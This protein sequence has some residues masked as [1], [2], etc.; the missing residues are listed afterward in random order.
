[1]IC[2]QDSKHDQK[3]DISSETAWQN[4]KRKRDLYAS[5]A[6]M[7]T[8]SEQAQDVGDR[9]HEQKKAAAVPE[10]GDNLVCM[11]VDEP[12]PASQGCAETPHAEQQQHQQQQQQESP[13]TSTPAEKAELLARLQAE[14]V[15]LKQHVS[16]MK[17]L[18][19]LTTDNSEELLCRSQASD[20]LHLWQSCG[21]SFFLMPW[22]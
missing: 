15:S 16:G 13:K 14:A 20:L 2:L 11:E 4:K 19:P 10:A 22:S 1:L 5:N 17:P 8:T 3:R 12:A 7:H 18:A 21:Q 6:A 9:G